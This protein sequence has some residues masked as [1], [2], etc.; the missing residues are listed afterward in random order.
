MTARTSPPLR[1]CAKCHAWRAPDE[2]VDVPVG[3][4]PDPAARERC[5]RGE[6]YL[7]TSVAICRA[8]AF[9]DELEEESR[10][11]QPAGGDPPGATSREPMK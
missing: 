3:P 6:A 1:R 5:R 2:L 9:G 11:T 8:C 4:G 7:S 10:T